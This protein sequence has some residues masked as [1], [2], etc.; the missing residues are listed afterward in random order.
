MT[1]KIYSYQA[2][3]QGAK[4]L[5]DA[6]N[7]RRIKHE[8]SRFVA[9]PTDIIINWG[10]STLPAS[11]LSAVLLASNKLQFLQRMEQHD[12]PTPDWTTAVEIAQNWLDTGHV[13]MARTIL[14][15]HSANGLVVVEPG[16][17]LPRAP[18]YT[19]Y[20][21]K[22]HEYRVHVGFGNIIDIQKKA[23]RA[24]VDNDAVNWKVRNLDG[25]FIY[26]RNDVE[27]PN[28]VQTAVNAA[29]T[30]LPELS[31]GAYD[32]IYNHH[33]NAAAVL[34]VNTAPGIMGTTLENYVTMFREN[35]LNA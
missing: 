3:S 17:T 28:V 24:D 21:K 31:Y 33:N 27:L 20:F 14:N 23:R 16:G 5:A 25:G 9:R 10:S 12:V 29:S 2:F 34:E 11:L 32:V 8:G 18:L 35:V 22:K 26:A 7:I 19:K 1:V 15:S 4:A 30:A 13:V 6:L